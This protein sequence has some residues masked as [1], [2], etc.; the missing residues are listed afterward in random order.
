M[1]RTVGRRCFYEGALL[2][3]SY[4]LTGNLPDYVGWAE[5]M[6]VGSGIRVDSTEEVRP[7]I[8]KAK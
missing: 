6:G 5:A 4:P 1:V 8:D 3:R 2:P 7:A